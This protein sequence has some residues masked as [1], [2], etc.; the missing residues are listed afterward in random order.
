MWPTALVDDERTDEH[1]EIFFS[2]NS[3][4]NDFQNEH[5][6]AL[7]DEGEGCFMFGAR[8]FP[9]FQ[10]DVEISNITAPPKLVSQGSTNPKFFYCNHGNIL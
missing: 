2:K 3:S 10:S 6:Y 9:S 5:G 8:I 4:M 7:N 1:V